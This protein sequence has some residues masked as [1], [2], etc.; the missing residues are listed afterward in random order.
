MKLLATGEFAKLC[1]T[2][3][4]TLIFYDKQG[5]FKPAYVAGNSYRKYKIGQYFE[6]DIITLLK[7]TGS[8]LAEIREYMGDKKPDKMLELFRGKREVLKQEKARLAR[9]MRIVDNLLSSAEEA[10]SAQYD[11]FEIVEMKE[12]T[13]EIV[14]IGPIKQDSDEG[15]VSLFVEFTRY[16]EKQN[17]VAV[18]PFGV[19]ATRADALSRRYIIE[20]FFC[21]AT[22]QTPTVDFH[23]KPSGKYA[24]IYHIGNQESHKKTYIELIDRINALGMKISGD[25]YLYNLVNYIMS[26]QEK[27]EYAMKY[28]VSVE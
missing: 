12:E 1:G 11:T 7:E 13:L 25:I 21:R 3:K 14:R 4:D 26:E 10:I 20:S 16:F 22:K 15:C 9:R 17:R 2:S 27:S 24:I 28:C 8:S 6:F 23:V 19:L 5:L 18:A